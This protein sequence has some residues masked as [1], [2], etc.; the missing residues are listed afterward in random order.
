MYQKRKEYVEL[1][2]KEFQGR[3]ISYITSDRV[4]FETQIASDTID[5]FVAHLDR[6]GVVNRI[7]L[8]LYTLGGN[9]SAAWNIVNLLRMYCDELLVIVPHKAHSAGTII[10]LGADSIIMTKQATLSPIDPSVTTPF[11]T[12]DQNHKPLPV[13]VEA[14]NGYIEL[15]KKEFLLTSPE[16]LQGA[17]YKLIDHVHPLVLGQA[18]RVRAQVKM[19]ADKLLV[20]QIKDEDETSKKDKIN[21][22]I[23]FLCSDSGSHDYTINRREAKNKLKLAVQNPNDKQYSII[24]LLYDDFSN[25]LGFGQVFDPRFI[26]G[27]YAVRRAFIESNSGGSD[28]FVTEA[29]IVPMVAPN[30]QHTFGNEISFEGWRHE[31]VITE[32]PPLD[33][34]QGGEIRYEATNEHGL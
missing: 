34:I 19:L 26:S 5:L 14:I 17:L 21:R 25:E 33:F 10:S 7:I 8:Y 32:M 3:L 2:E 15:A 4:G 20:H 6:I 13:S 31:S 18:Y 1:L 11:N 24:K 29:R 30:G 23:E 9:I 22:I 16:Q 28:F 27:A 12:I